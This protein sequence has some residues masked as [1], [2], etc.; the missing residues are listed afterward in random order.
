MTEDRT[1]EKLA[2][3][4]AP[5]PLRGRRPDGAEL[6]T[7][8]KAILIAARGYSDDQAFDELLDV[9]LRHHLTVH[10]AARRLVDHAAGASPR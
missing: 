6:L 10:G 2:P 4:P 7:T 5:A 9:A 3:L 1:D 8:A